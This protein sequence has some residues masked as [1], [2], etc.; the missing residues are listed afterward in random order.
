MSII[1]VRE[2]VE[3]KLEVRMGCNGESFGLLGFD[4]PRLGANGYQRC[5]R[6]QDSRRSLPQLRSVQ[7]LSLRC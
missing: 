2:G 1:E 5:K 3:W 7:K 6:T 4:D